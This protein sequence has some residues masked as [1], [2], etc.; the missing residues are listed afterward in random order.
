MQV[1][2]NS[3]LLRKGDVSY[4]SGRRMDVKHAVSNFSTLGYMGSVDLV[5]GGSTD[6]SPSSIGIFILWREEKDPPSKSPRG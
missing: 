3:S 4:H 1:D 5:E 6:H 2:D